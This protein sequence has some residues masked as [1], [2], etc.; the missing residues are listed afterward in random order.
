VHAGCE[1]SNYNSSVFEK[2]EERK[3]NKEGE[4]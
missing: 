4:I 1:T 3:G 2:E